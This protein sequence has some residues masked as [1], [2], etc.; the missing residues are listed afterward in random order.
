MILS[1]N[2]GDDACIILP[3]QRSSASLTDSFGNCTF[4]HRLQV[5]V[6]KSLDIS[7][8]ESASLDISKNGQE[9]DQDARDGDHHTQRSQSNY[10][11]IFEFN[12]RMAATYSRPD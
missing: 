10:E 8:Y 1:T 5:A 7:F 4:H 2:S 9:R 3:G 6:N 12:F 11:K